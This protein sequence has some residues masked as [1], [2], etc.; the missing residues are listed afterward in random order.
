MGGIHKTNKLLVLFISFT[1]FLTFMFTVDPLHLNL[2][3]GKRIGNSEHTQHNKNMNHLVFLHIPKTGG[4]VVEQLFLHE[5][6]VS[7]PNTVPKK[8]LMAKGYG[9]CAAVQHVPLNWLFKNIS[10]DNDTNLNLSVD[11]NIYNKLQNI[12]TYYYSKLPYLRTDSFAVVRNPYSRFISQY[13]WCT[14]PNYRCT[15]QLM[16]WFSAYCGKYL[17]FKLCN[18]VDD[19]R[20]NATFYHRHL[21]NSHWKQLMQN[22]SIWTQFDFCDVKIFNQYS[23]AVL[24]YLIEDAYASK[25]KHRRG[26]L[27]CHYVKQTEYI[28]NYRDNDRMIRYILRTE[29]L[30]DDLIQLGKIYNVH[31]DDRMITKYREQWVWPKNCKNI[32]LSDLN[33]EN[34]QLLNKL[35]YDDFINFNYSMV[36]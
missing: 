6:N 34:I 9:A 22:K 32:K 3:I 5:F 16:D 14:A 27:D 36:G 24:R 23:Y 20:N 8:T 1:I 4:K 30:T 31:I 21:N 28:Y 17:S 35:Y 7:F 19:L 15:L 26:I 33:T 2:Y 25:D 11:S 18:K 13:Q 29:H 10:S 12:S